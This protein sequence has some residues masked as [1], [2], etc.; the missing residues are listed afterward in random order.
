[1]DME[2]SLGPQHGKFEAKSPE[3]EELKVRVEALQAQVRLL[4]V[5]VAQHRGKFLLLSLTVQTFQIALSELRLISVMEQLFQVGEFLRGS[6]V[7]DI[8]S[9][10]HA[11]KI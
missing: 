1:M 11:T 7:P 5:Y 10:F 4:H 6:K 2:A 8:L 9:K 3:I